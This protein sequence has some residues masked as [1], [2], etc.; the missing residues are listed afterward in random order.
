MI[1]SFLQFLWIADRIIEA[2][3]D[4]KELAGKAL[5]VV[6]KHIKS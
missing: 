3:E 4:E 5:N 2:I 6:V 1:S